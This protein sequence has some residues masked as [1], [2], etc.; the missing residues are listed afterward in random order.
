MPSTPLNN[1]DPNNRRNIRRNLSDQIISYTLPSDTTLSGYGLNL[2]PATTTFYRSERYDEI[3]DGLSD[4]LINDIPEFEPIVVSSNN[5]N[6]D[7]LLGEGSVVSISLYDDGNNARIV[8]AS[9][10][11]PASALAP[12]DVSMPSFPEAWRRT[13]ENIDVGSGGQ[14]FDPNGFVD[15]SN[16]FHPDNYDTNAVP[17]KD[18][19]YYRPLKIGTKLYQK[20]NNGILSDPYEPFWKKDSSYSAIKEFDT[21]TGTNLSSSLYT[22]QNPAYKELF[23]KI[24]EDRQIGSLPGNSA[25]LISN[26]GLIDLFGNYNGKDFTGGIIQVSNLGE[27]INVY[28]LVGEWG[29]QSAGQTLRLVSVSS[30]L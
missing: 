10:S 11:W 19:F 8:D 15:K 27:V 20:N 17:V 4:E 13:I 5:L 30:S 12:P 16:V 28:K 18:L 26:Q 3:I 21:N 9:I 7:L 29:N 1:F 14:F 2:I 22:G 24:T 6:S 25:G 23:A